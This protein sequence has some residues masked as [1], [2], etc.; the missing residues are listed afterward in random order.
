MYVFKG[1]GVVWDSSSNSVLAEF[2]EGVFTTEDKARAD[3]LVRLGYSFESK[4][5]E[6][7]PAKEKTRKFQK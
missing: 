7:V 5:A 6:T 3:K 1:Y 4:S 2:K